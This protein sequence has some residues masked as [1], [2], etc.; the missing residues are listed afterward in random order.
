MLPSY[1]PVSL[2]EKYG[3]KIWFSLECKDEMAAFK[4]DPEETFVVE[5]IYEAAGFMGSFHGSPLADWEE[6]EES[7]IT[8]GKVSTMNFDLGFHFNL[9]HRED[10]SSSFDDA[11]FMGSTK[12]GTS[13]VTIAVVKMPLDLVIN[14]AYDASLSEMSH[15]SA[16][17]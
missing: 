13:N 7:D 6:V 8:D 10:G 3:E 9:K 11:H 17:I 2:A 14:L 15:A 16:S 5:V 1:L 4:W 12:T